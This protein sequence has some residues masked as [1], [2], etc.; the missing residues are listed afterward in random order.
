[1]ARVKLEIPKSLPIFS[2]DITLTINFIN[3]GGHLGNDSVL[4]LCHEARLRYLKSIEQS[5]LNYYGKSIIQADAVV[6][7]KSEG[8]L[9]DIL[10]VDLYMD[11]I[12]DYG[13]DFFYIFTNVETNKEVARAK[14]GIVFFDYETRKICRRP[15]IS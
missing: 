11:D 15:L 8:F 7:Y 1:M 12:N 4:T 6:V 9:G 2:S 3:Y 13:H 14:T 5:E 10:R